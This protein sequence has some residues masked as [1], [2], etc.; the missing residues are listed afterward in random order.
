MLETIYQ[1]Y[2]PKGVKFYYVYKSLAHPELNGYV[3]PFT[4]EERLMHVKEVERKIGSKITWLC[5]SMSND[6]KHALGAENNSEY[7][8]DPDGK[9][10]RM[11]TWSDPKQLRKDLEELV[12]PVDKPTQISD[13]N[14]KT[15][16]PKPKTASKGVVP[17][18]K[19]PGRMLAVKIEPKIEDTPFYV[20][21]RAEVEQKVLRTGEGK[22]YIGFHLDPIYHVHWNNLTEPLQYE[23]KPP[24]GTTVSPVSGEGP[25][26]KE[27]S[28]IDPREFLVDIKSGKSKKPIELAVHYFVC[29]DEEGWC[30]PVT[31]RYAIY[32]ERDPDGGVVFSRGR[33]GGGSSGGRGGS[34]GGGFMARILESDKDGDGKIS[35]EEIP[36]RFKERFDFMDQNGDGFIDKDEVEKLTERFGG[37]GRSGGP[38]SRRRL[39]CPDSK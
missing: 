18:I 23:L 29:H 2:S 19:V 33:M 17:R 28:D 25:N 11:R 21:L 30:K 35:K 36:E 26:V 16:A 22:V 12:G 14:L 8:I 5:D 13:L 4:L 38:R 1:D 32:L 7:L 37:R 15:V 34:P 6:L 27:E 20:K 9:I 10:V 24:A 31:Q 3:K 39:N